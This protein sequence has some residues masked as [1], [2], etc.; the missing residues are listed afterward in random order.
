M[1]YNVL[2]TFLPHG[3]ATVTERTLLFEDQ[4]CGCGHPH[5]QILHL[6]LRELVDK[7]LTTIPHFGDEQKLRV[8]LNVTYTSLQVKCKKIKSLIW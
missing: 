7:H 1:Y 8:G 6:C 5:Y 2:C 4:T 3:N